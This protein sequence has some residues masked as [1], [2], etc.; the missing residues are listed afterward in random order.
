MRRHDLNTPDL[1]KGRIQPRA[2]V[3]GPAL[4][5]ERRTPLNPRRKV[6]IRIEIAWLFR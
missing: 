4:L 2:C 1:E 5:G 3:V 6:I